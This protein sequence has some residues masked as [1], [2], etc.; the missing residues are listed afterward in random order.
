MDANQLTTEQAR[1]IRESLAPS[2]GYLSRLCRRMEQTGF[3]PGDK[4]YRLAISGQDALQA[5]CVELHYRSCTGG[6]GR[7]S[8]GRRG[9]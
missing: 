3:E 9:E 7:P 4:L 2:L 8:R 5:L 1:R 6:V